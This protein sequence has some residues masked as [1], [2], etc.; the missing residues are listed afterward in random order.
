M[1]IR[2]CWDESILVITCYHPHQNS[3][4]ARLLAPTGLSWCRWK[5]LAPTSWTWLFWELQL[6][7]T[8]PEITQRHWCG[9]QR[10][11]GFRARDTDL[12]KLSMSG[13]SVYPRWFARG[14]DS[15][16]ARTTVYSRQRDRQ[17][18]RE[19]DRQMSTK[20]SYESLSAVH[21]P[22]SFPYTINSCNCPNNPLR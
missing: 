7:T 21:W 22:G 5:L 3:F 17:R 15:Y 6:P 18:Q 10:G 11:W 9:C 2:V 14:R 13:A 1:Y 20:N 8:L 12:I 4:M 16:K 19:T